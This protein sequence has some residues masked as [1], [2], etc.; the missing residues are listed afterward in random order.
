MRGHHGHD[1]FPPD[2]LEAIAQRVA[3]LPLHE[4]T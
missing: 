3:A 1:P 4:I 2:L